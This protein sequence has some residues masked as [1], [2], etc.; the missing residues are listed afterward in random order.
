MGVFIRT[1]VANVVHTGD[2]KLDQ[3]PI[4]G[5]LVDYAALT[6]FAKVGVDLLL[7]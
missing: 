6:K 5:R 7:V 1:P 3:T 4:D 2:F